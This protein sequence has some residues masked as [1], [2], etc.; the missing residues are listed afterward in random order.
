MKS[1]VILQLLNAFFVSLG[2]GDR[3]TVI[4]LDVDQKVQGILK[5]LSPS[6]PSSDPLEIHLFHDLL[7]EADASLAALELNNTSCLAF[8]RIAFSEWVWAVRD[9]NEYVE[10]V[11]EFFD[12][13][14]SLQDELEGRVQNFPD[15]RARY[16]QM[17]RKDATP[18]I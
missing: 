17:E 15:E 13:H 2:A 11:E 5:Q 14:G 6:L 1:F 16:I 7:R 12:W 3:T 8:K 4:G 10:A 9:P 18:A